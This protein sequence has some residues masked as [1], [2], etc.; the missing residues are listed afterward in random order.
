LSA[1]LNN[2]AK[3]SW[4]EVDQLVDKPLRDT[5]T[6]SLGDDGYVDAWIERMVQNGHDTMAEDDV[7]D[8]EPV[9]RIG[10]HAR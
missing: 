5:V 3:L 1:Y 7:P 10:L 6:E 8:A 2:A 9:R 4:E